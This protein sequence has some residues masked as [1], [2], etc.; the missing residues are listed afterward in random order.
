MSS[1][2]KTDSRSGGIEVV[3]DQG[4][5]GSFEI[6]LERQQ[7]APEEPQPA[8]DRRASTWN[9]QPEQ[10]GLKAHNKRIALIALSA[11]IFVL[12]ILGIVL[13]QSATWLQQSR[14]QTVEVNDQP[15]FR[16]Y[17]IAGQE[18]ERVRNVRLDAPA[19]LAADEDDDYDDDALYDDED[20]DAEDFDDGPTRINLRSAASGTSS[21][22][23]VEDEHLTDREIRLRNR[24]A[25]QDRAQ[26]ELREFIE[27]YQNQRERPSD[28]PSSPRDPEDFYDELDEDEYFDEYDEYDEEYDEFDEFDEYVPR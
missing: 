9:A 11:A 17:V 26:Q 19:D 4:D 22:A 15:R 24:K 12:L 27:D 28:T 6:R 16:G 1:E 18:P 3:A 25:R 13:A 20:E 10:T 23:S 2:H 8:D 14:P 7:E 21:S 5:D